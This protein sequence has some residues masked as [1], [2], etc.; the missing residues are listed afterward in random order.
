MGIPLTLQAVPDPSR[1]LTR[2]RTDRKLGTLFAD[3]YSMGG[4]PGTWA[5]LD[6]ADESLEYLVE[7]GVFASRDEAKKTFAELLAEWEAAHRAQRGLYQ[8]RVFLE[9]TAHDLEERMTQ[10]L[11]AD[12]EC[13]S[14]EMIG[15][16]FHGEGSLQSWSDGEFYPLGFV[17]A[18]R[19]KS[20]ADVL[21]GLNDASLFD[22]DEQDWL[23][24]DYRELKKLCFES[25]D[26]GEAL[27]V[28][29]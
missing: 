25:A 16:L 22:E 12:G 5:E 23:G 6:D 2:L 11:R 7:Q 14:A 28:G 27:I 13:P 1:L 9:T 24:N 17:S 26:R 3:F 19:V 8:I 21:R 20:I 29:A 4:G 10:P 15:D 18:A